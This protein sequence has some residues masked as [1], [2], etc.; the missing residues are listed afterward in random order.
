MHKKGQHGDSTFFCKIFQTG[1]V[2]SL[3]AT[4]LDFK[5]RFSDFCLEEISIIILT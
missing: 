4:D 3:K 2:S 5:A 1:R